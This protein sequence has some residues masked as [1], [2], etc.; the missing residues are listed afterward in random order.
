MAQCLEVDAPTER[1]ALIP[2]QNP[3]AACS[4]KEV[5]IFEPPTKRAIGLLLRSTYD[6]I[7]FLGQVLR[8][9]QEKLI[10]GKD[11]CLTLRPE[12]RSCEDGEVLFQV[13]APV[14]TPVIST[15]YSGK[16]YALYDRNCERNRQQPCDYSIQVLAILELL[17]NE[18]RSAKDILSTPRVQVVP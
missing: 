17:I 1:Y 2:G 3:N 7:Q 5:I 12:G 14:G 4:Q 11:R 13:N 8:F 15:L 6:I 18:N 10:E 16:W 9:Q